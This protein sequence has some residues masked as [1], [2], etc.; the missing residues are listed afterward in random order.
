MARTSADLIAR[1]RA[2]AQPVADLCTEML[3]ED[4]IRIVDRTLSGEDQRAHFDVLMKCFTLCIDR[5]EQKPS[6]PSAIVLAAVAVMIHERS[7]EVTT[8][9]SP[10]YQRFLAEFNRAV[11]AV[12]ASGAGPLPAL[13]RRI[14]FSYRKVDDLRL[15]T[16]SGEQFTVALQKDGVVLTAPDGE[17]FRFWK[18]VLPAHICGTTAT[19]QG[20]QRARVT[21]IE[22]G[23]VSFT[24]GCGCNYIATDGYVPGTLGVEHG[25]DG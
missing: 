8:W 17:E 1:S 22:F 4:P 9:P 21:G 25:A 6:F 11:R 19:L 10:V 2:L 12:G 18:L 14:E 13:M 3:R 23:D 24:T 5:Q 15:R 7:L 20:G 16:T